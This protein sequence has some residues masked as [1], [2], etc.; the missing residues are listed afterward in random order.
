MELKIGTDSPK[1]NTNEI[2][3]KM[4]WNFKYENIYV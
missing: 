4:K 2:V 1:G 3:S